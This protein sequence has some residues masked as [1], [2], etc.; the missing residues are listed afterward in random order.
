MKKINYNKQEVKQFL[1]IYIDAYSLLT[2]TLDDVS[3]N[4]LA[5]ENR[6]KEEIFIVKK[7]PELY[8]RFQLDFNNDQDGVEMTLYGIRLETDKELEERIM[9]NERNLLNIKEREK[10]QLEEWEKDELAN[11]LR[12]KEKFEKK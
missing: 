9:I 4:I 6:A 3:K 5:L 2:G 8:L 11:Y 7:N 1:S 10:K 12:L